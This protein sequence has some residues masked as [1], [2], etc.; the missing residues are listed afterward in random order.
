MGRQ[1]SATENCERPAAPQFASRCVPKVGKCGRRAS[2]P[3]QSSQ[4]KQN[5][6]ARIKSKVCRDWPSRDDNNTD[7]NHDKKIEYIIIAVSRY[8]I[9][10]II[11]VFPTGGLYFDF[12]PTGGLSPFIP[13][14]GLYSRIYSHG[15]VIFSNLFPREGYIFPTWKTNGIDLGK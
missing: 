7:G 6:W 5:L 10:Y 12:I 3:N 4:G 9:I 14:G 1:R 11:W 8:N 2:H 15:R 13:T